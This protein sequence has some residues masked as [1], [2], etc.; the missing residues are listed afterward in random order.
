MKK[1][2]LTDETKRFFCITLH[3]IVALRDFNDVKKV[4]R[5]VG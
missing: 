4:T 1:Y 5:A 2:K 3:R